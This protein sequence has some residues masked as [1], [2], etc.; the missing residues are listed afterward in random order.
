MGIIFEQILSKHTFY[1][2]LY[3]TWSWEKKNCLKR[4][5]SCG[6]GAF[7]FWQQKDLELSGIRHYKQI[8][9][10]CCVSDCLH[11]DPPQKIPS[12][13]VEVLTNQQFSF[14]GTSPQV[15]IIQRW[16]SSCLPYCM[17]REKAFSPP[18]K[19]CWAM[20]AVCS[21]VKTALFLSAVTKYPKKAT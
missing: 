13:P 17:C 11:T 1:L 2:L 16:P 5:G 4:A 20:L 21:L 7:L 10:Q 18:W 8:C 15:F 6:D 12:V 19:F 9:L 14:S 3:L